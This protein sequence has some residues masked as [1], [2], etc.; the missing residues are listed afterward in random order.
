MVTA[1]WSDVRFTTNDTSV[2]TGKPVLERS[3]C[4]RQFRVEK[5]SFGHV[6]AA[7]NHGWLAGQTL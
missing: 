1:L 7:M 5:G 2:N 6:L 4:K 3:L